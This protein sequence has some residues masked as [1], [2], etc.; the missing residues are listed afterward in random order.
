MSFANTGPDIVIETW[1]ISLKKPGLCEELES[2]FFITTQQ[3]RIKRSLTQSPIHKN[4]HIRAAGEPIHLT[5]TWSE[6]VL[7]PPLEQ[8]RS[9]RI[10]VS[11]TY[12]N[13]LWNRLFSAGETVLIVSSQ[14]WGK[15]SLRQLQLVHTAAARV[16][17]HTKKLDLSLNNCVSQHTFKIP[18]P[19]HAEAP[20]SAWRS[21]S[22]RRGP[23]KVKWILSA[24]A[25]S[26]INL[27]RP[28]NEVAVY[29]HRLWKWSKIF[30]F[31][32]SLADSSIISLRIF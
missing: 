9:D 32:L 11:A 7:L 21:R 24:E 26:S 6:T 13:N 5:S 31:L 20:S 15:K 27:F 14:V 2:L 3:I 17:K 25:L 18:S 16:I 10:P 1:I 19:L 4:V 23:L 12:G 28:S 29:E 8:S 30:F 22:P